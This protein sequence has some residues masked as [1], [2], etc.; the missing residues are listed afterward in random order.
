M[1][2]VRY[3]WAGALSHIVVTGVPS[4]FKQDGDKTRC[5]TGWALQCRDAMSGAYG[6][7]WVRPQHTPLGI[8]YGHV[9]A[10][11]SLGQASLQN[12]TQTHVEQITVCIAAPIAKPDVF[13]YRQRSS[14]IVLFGVWRTWVSKTVRLS[15]AVVVESSL[16]SRRVPDATV[17]EPQVPGASS[18][19]LCKLLRAALGL[20]MDGR[21]PAGGE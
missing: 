18:S 10:R 16:E 12:L 14:I 4:S 15:R 1:S 9:R 2:L 3:G 7:G 13:L 8:W 19:A 17:Q 20:S 6:R 11:A 5:A 21:Q